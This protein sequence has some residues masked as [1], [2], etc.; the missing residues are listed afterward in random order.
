[1]CCGQRPTSAAKIHDLATS[2]C[3]AGRDKDAAFIT[4][5]FRHNMIE[6]D[7]LLQRIEALDA[8]HP[9]QH[10][11]QWAMRRHTESTAK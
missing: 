2:K 5:L 8:Q 7:T 9:R 4:E 10:I 6:L 11:A 3:V 1:M